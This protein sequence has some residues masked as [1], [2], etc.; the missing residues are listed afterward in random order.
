MPAYGV[1]FGREQQR[2]MKYQQNRV[3]ALVG[4]GCNNNLQIGIKFT[5]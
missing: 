3:Y 1:R 4:T 5:V 2:F